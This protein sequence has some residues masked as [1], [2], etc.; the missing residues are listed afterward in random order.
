M[1]TDRVRASADRPREGQPSPGRAPAELQVARAPCVPGAAIHPRQ[2]CTAG[3][4]SRPARPRTLPHPLTSG[5][6]PPRPAHLPRGSNPGRGGVGGQGLRLG[7]QGP[8]ACLPRSSPSGS[9]SA[10]MSELPLRAALLPGCQRGGR[11]FVRPR[12]W[13]RAIPAEA[14]LQ[15]LLRRLSGC[16]ALK[17]HGSPV[18][19]PSYCSLCLH[20]LPSQSVCSARHTCLC[21]LYPFFPRSL[22][23]RMLNIWAQNDGHD[24]EQGRQAHCP[25]G[26]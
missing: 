7:G 26:A 10:A 3:A 14:R 4:P 24:G 19:G 5:L 22:E 6:T 18:C 8:L 20:L 23:K 12:P 17:P 16:P 21:P 9:T 13:R 11:G 1:A 25:H 2:G 15:H